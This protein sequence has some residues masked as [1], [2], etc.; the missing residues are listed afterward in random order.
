MFCPQ[1]LKKIA[2]VEKPGQRVTGALVMELIAQFHIGNGEADVFAALKREFKSL[3]CGVFRG[4]GR[5]GDMQKAHGVTMGDDGNAQGI[6]YGAQDRVIPHMTAFKGKPI[7]IKAVAPPASQ[8]PT[9][10][11]RNVFLQMRITPGTG[12]IQ[13]IPGVGIDIKLSL[14]VRQGLGHEF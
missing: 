5:I 13:H 1:S 14:R 6:F 4:F 11:W 10:I 3:L 7:R 8:C 2:P 12:A 9:A